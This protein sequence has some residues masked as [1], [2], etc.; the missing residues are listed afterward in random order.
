MWD[1]LVDLLANWIS[2]P[3]LDMTFGLQDGG[4]VLEQF[5]FDSFLQDSEHGFDLG[6]ASMAFGS[7]DPVEAATGDA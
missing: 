6:D 2:Q 3:T 7:F 4:D 1:S 5:D